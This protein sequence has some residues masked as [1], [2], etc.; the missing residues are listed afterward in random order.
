MVLCHGAGVPFTGELLPYLT[1]ERLS[2]WVRQKTIQK[3]VESLRLSP[4]QKEELKAL[5]QAKPH[6]EYLLLRIRF[7]FFGRLW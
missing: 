3:A 4:L 7:A 5:R 1:Q 6:P 2:P